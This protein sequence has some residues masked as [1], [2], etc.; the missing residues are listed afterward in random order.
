MGGDHMARKIE[1]KSSASFGDQEASITNEITIRCHIRGTRPLLMNAFVSESGNGPSKRGKVYDDN[2]E[3]QKRLYLGPDGSICTPATHIEA[4]M[5]KSASDFKF[6][7]KKTYKDIIKSGVFVEPLMI[8][9]LKTDWKVDRQGVV[10]QK[11]RIMRC[12]PRFDEWEL[13]FEMV[14]RDERLEALNVRNILESAGKYVG[15][16]DYRPRYGLFQIAEFEVIDRAEEKA[17]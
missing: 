6:S 7:G 14:L 1:K 8:P 3:A 12:R 11:A 13:K 5:V 9:H 2:D 10:V 17:A 4:C 15:I 16:G